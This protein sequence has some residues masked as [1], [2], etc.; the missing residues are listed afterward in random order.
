MRIFIV[1]G[2]SLKFN[3]YKHTAFEA[4]LADSFKMKGPHDF[5]GTFKAFVDLKDDDAIVV[6]VFR[7]EVASHLKQI[8][9]VHD[10]T[11]RP[12]SWT[13][14]LRYSEVSGGMF[15]MLPSVVAGGF[16]D[17]SVATGKR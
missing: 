16:S 1:D 3:K 13:F 8:Y 17:L 14:G 2:I 5:M 15:W 12:E 9:N 10:L 4:E 11:F 6:E 7:K